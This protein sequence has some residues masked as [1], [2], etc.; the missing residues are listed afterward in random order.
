M[1]TIARALENGNPFVYLFFIVLFIPPVV[2]LL[3]VA[4]EKI[5]NA[6]ISL[7]NQY[8]NRC[9]EKENKEHD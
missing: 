2:I 4:Y 8:N 9:K 6:C 1:F 5:K 3:F 7:K